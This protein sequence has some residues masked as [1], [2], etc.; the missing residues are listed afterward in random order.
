MEAGKLRHRL[1]IQTAT[2]SKGPHG[3]TTRTWVTDRRRS[4]NVRELSG[5]ELVEA[6]QVNARVTLA[7]DLRFDSALNTSNRFLYGARVLNIEAVL[8]P[9]GRRI[10]T[11]ALCREEKA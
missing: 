9:D 8:N 11:L 10:A 4:G 6:Q 3:G 5:S 7:V 1:Q 2:K